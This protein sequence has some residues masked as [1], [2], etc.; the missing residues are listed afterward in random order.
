MADTS[1]CRVIAC[2]TLVDLLVLMVALVALLAVLLLPALTVG[3][4][5]AR[6]AACA[7]N[8]QQIV[9]GSENYLSDYSD[10]FP[11]WQAAEKKGGIR[12][13]DDHGLYKDPIRNE[14]IQVSPAT[15]AN[16]HYGRRF[17][18]T[19]VGRWRGI[20]QVAYDVE[21]PPNFSRGHLSAAPLNLGH[22]LVLGYLPDA[23]VLYCPSGTEMP[24]KELN[25]LDCQSPNLT[26]LNDFTRLGGTDGRPLTHG[27]WSWV[28]A[29]TAGMPGK[30]RFKTAIGQYNYRCAPNIRFLRFDHA[31]TVAATRPAVTSTYGSPAFTTPRSLC[32]RALIS[33]TFDK[34]WRAGWPD[35]PKDMGAGLFHHKDGYNVLYGDYHCAWY[36][37]PQH[38]ISKW[39]PCDQPPGWPHAEKA[40]HPMTS[41]EKN[42]SCSAMDHNASLSGSYA[43]WHFFDEAAGVDVGLADMG[44][45]P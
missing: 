39:A 18:A 7:A 38:I 8:L 3:R 5:K 1:R 35:G 26:L 45:L 31:F 32:G 4:E 27:D 16:D 33:D 34:G 13:T 15:G 21:R 19:A 6:R 12:V 10:Y 23:A 43:V 20:A 37:D 30:H 42:L 24:V 44:M 29:V 17:A 14:T 28:T 36:G 2:F 9:A 40:N 41:I 25:G 22:V 11:S